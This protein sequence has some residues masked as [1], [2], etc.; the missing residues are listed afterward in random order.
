MAHSL[1]AEDTAFYRLAILDVGIDFL[2]YGMQIAIFIAVIAASIRGGTRPRCVIILTTSVFLS[3]TLEVVLGFMFVFAQIPRSDGDN[4]TLR[5]LGLNVPAQL[6]IIFNFLASDAVVVWRA[7]ILW[8]QSRVAKGILVSV[9]FNFV[10]QTVHWKE[11]QTP[12]FTLTIW[13][14]LLVTN[15]VATG[16]V[17]LQ[18]WYYR[19]DIQ[20]ALGQWRKTT[21]VEKVLILLLDSGLVYCLILGTSLAVTFKVVKYGDPAYHITLNIATSA[22]HSI[23]VWLLPDL[24]RS[25]GCCAAIDGVFPSTQHAGLSAHAVCGTGARPWHAPAWW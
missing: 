17:A 23:A 3:S 8:P 18:V 22:Y 2:F 15:M 25:R 11:E 4:A 9:V 16:L 14:P 10:W 12:A 5:L 6:F 24:H 13:L 20:R 7:W 21:R 1:T 19:R